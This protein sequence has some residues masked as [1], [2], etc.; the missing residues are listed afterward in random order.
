LKILHGLMR[1]YANTF[2]LALSVFFLGIGVLAKDADTKAVNLP[3]LPW[4]G[5]DLVSWLFY[6]GGFGLLAV[7]LNV[8]GLFRYLLPVAALTWLVILFK[9]FF[10]GAYSY[11]GEEPFYWAVA[12]VAGAAGALLCSLR[13]LLSARK[14]KA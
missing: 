3:M 13:E 11:G 1:G 8:T 5:D 9:G 4:S 12:L 10:W 14:K 7:V 6:L 2:V